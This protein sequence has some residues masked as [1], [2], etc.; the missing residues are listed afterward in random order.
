MNNILNEFVGEIIVENYTKD[1]ILISSGQ[2]VKYAS[3][4][5]IKDLIKVLNLLIIA[6]NQQRR[7]SAYRE[8]YSNAV[9]RMRLQ[10]KNAEKTHEKSLL[11]NS[12]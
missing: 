4:E 11:N 6:R 10:L 1:I 7:S 9:R 12:K 5:H 8:A 2:A 3:P